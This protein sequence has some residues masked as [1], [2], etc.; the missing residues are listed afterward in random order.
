MAIQPKLSVGDQT[1]S[2]FVY[3]DDTDDTAF[4]NSHDSCVQPRLY[5]RSAVLGLKVSWPK[6]KIQNLGVGPS[7]DDI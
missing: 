1:F 2:D 7:P 4:L 5:A 6:T 3:A